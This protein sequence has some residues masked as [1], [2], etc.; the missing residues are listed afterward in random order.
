VKLH[1]RWSAIVSAALLSIFVGAATSRAYVLVADRPEKRI[2]KYSD[3]GAF[4]GVV[5]EDPVNW[6]GPVNGSGPNSMVLSADGTKL[7]VAA[8]NN[9]VTRFDFNGTTATNPQVYM[10]NGAS[11]FNDPGGVILSPNG[12]TVYVSNREF[13][14]GT[15]VARLDVNGVSQGANLGG[16]GGGLTGLEFNPGGE[17]LA[18]IFGSNFMGGGVGGGVLRYDNSAGSF[19]SLVPNSL[20]VAGVATL[21]R[22]NNDLYLTAS[23]GPDFAGRIGKYN[24]N[25]GAPDAAFGTGGLVTP[26]L[27][28]PAGLTSA[29]D[30]T[31]FL[32]SLLTFTTTGAGRVD[33]YLWDGTRVGVW[34]DNSTATPS[35]G[36]VEATALLDVVPE[37]ASLAMAPALAVGLGLVRRFRRR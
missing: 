3:S 17:L 36:F 16:G 31:G 32:V 11:T 1:R 35:Q 4:L 37:P 29:A 33:K 10:S 26:Q 18:G 21:L 34:A 13:G 14:F 2:L 8:L 23:V 22:H 5:V 30:G 9:I 12:A 20:N 27:S 24:V 6:A 28:F 19:V 7:Y 25:T 15:S